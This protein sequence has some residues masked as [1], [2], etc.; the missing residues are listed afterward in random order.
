GRRIPVL[1]KG[2]TAE[3]LRHLERHRP[4]LE[5]L[6]GTEAIAV[7]AAGEI[8]PE[9]ATALIGELTVLVPMAGLIDAA[10]EF[11]RLEKLLARARADLAKA[12]AR[13]QNQSFVSNAPVA[14]VAGEKAR[15]AELERT[16]AG[17]S[18]QLERVRG[19]LRS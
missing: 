17:L 10:A 11:E 5:R 14:V 15:A 9:S 12:H 7:L 4:Y 8:A 19:M 16:A 1:L 18:T 2:A 13:L 6:A 3:D